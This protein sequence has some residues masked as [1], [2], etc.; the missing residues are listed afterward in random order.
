MCI[1]KMLI[2]IKSY[3]ERKE[4]EK[5]KQIK[6]LQKI[7]EYGIKSSAEYLERKIE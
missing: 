6:R 4:K 1:K 3:S 5:R 7:S 2:G